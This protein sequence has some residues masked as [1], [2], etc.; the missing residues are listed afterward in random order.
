MGTARH[1]MCELAFMEEG[2]SLVLLLT[3]YG[4][5]VVQAVEYSTHGLRLR[6]RRDTTSHTR[7]N[8]G[9]NLKI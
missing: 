3:N 2:A 5:S 8:K 1:G 9:R 7:Q 6:N 4:Y